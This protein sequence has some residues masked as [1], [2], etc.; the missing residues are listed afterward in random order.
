MSASD[1]TLDTLTFEDLVRLGLDDLPAASRGEWTQHGAVDPGVTLLELFAW[2]FEQRLFMADQLTEPIVRASL[3]LL[4][5]PAPAPDA[6]ATTVLSIVSPAAASPLPAGTVFG[7]DGDPQ[8]RR[9]ALDADAW[10]HPVTGVRV[11]G[12]LLR[13]GDVLEL[14]LEGAAG[15]P[16]AGV[17]LS[18]LVEVAAA[19]GVAAAWRPAAADT[20][21]PARL[22]WDAV[23]RDGAQAP[24]AV[25]DST[26]AL[27]RSG[28][29]RLAWPEVWDRPGTE[30]PRLRATAVAAS[31]AEPVLVLAVHPN[32]AVARHGVPRTADVSDQLAGFLP[33]PGQLLRV[34]GAAGLLCDGDGDVVLSVTERSG[35]THDWHGVRTWVSSGP[36]DRV[37]VV[38]RARGELH[39]GD[40]RRGRILRPASAP[41][42]RASHFLGAGREGNLGTSRGWSQE[43]GT[44]LAV[45]PVAA[46]DGADLEPLE[47]ARRRA[48]DAL[49]ARDR[50]VTVDDT[51]RLAESTPG[52]G[53]ERAH[54]SPGFHPGFPCQPVPGALTVTIVPHVDRTAEPDAWTA[55]PQPDRGALATTRERLERARLLGQEIF[56]LGPVYR[57]VTVDVAISAT[58]QGGDAR[59]RVVDALRRHLDA[60]VGGSEHDGWPFGGPVR[61]SALAG[62]VQDELGPEAT[63]TTL[64]AALDGGPASDCADLAIGPRELVWLGGVTIAWVSALPTG[65]GLR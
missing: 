58:A 12:R 56:V 54:V 45:N 3:R 22:R 30:P 13:D 28:L 43:D 60:L 55:A 18:L 51:G 20:Q 32:A 59:Q 27:R 57:R 36:A 23:G 24:V 53:L 19:P 64:A 21:P 61:P 35:E 6:A 39:F 8:G 33:L 2:Q 10:V 25:D 29:L 7:L 38:D 31:Y 5:V 1:M 46:E 14:E 62:V 47:D 48:T 9:F 41:Q 26:Q 17:E 44:A 40:G 34:P 15:A 65:G 50:T 11:T 4:G 49:S 16:A 63:V 37:F 42:A 52:L